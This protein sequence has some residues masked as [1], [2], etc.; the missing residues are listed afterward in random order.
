MVQVIT[1]E[2]ELNSSNISLVHQKQTTLEQ[3]LGNDSPDMEDPLEL[4]SAPVDVKVFK[5]ED[6]VFYSVSFPSSYFSQERF[7]LLLTNATSEQKPFQDSRDILADWIMPDRAA[8]IPT[9]KYLGH[10]VSLHES[11]GRSWFEFNEQHRHKFIAA[12]ENNDTERMINFL[13]QQSKAFVTK[14]KAIEEIKEIMQ[15]A[16]GTHI[17]YLLSTNG[18][19]GTWYRSTTGRRMNGN[20]LSGM[21]A[22]KKDE[23]MAEVNQFPDKFLYTLLERGALPRYNFFV[24][25]DNPDNFFYERNPMI[26]SVNYSMESL[27]DGRFKISYMGSWIEMG[28]EDGNFRKFD[29]N[30]AFNYKALS[31]RIIWAKSLETGERRYLTSG[32]PSEISSGIDLQAD[33][34][35]GLITVTNVSPE[36]RGRLP[37]ALTLEGSQRNQ[38]MS[39]AQIPVQISMEPY[40]SNILNGSPLFQKVEALYTPG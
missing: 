4:L 26:R 39:E 30:V 29:G 16:R 18:L 15:Q 1:S 11:I 40:R 7:I 17:P 8:Y 35:L 19:I 38:R 31:P 37:L 32:I 13:E 5:S 3:I 12:L 10:L 9:E 21:S 14:G 20:K 27:G 34:L 6:S 36:Q 33:S 24:D 28:L 25:E 23:I 2:P 22:E